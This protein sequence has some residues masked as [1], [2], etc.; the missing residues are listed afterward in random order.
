MVPLGLTSACRG[1]SEDVAAEMEDFLHHTKSVVTKGLERHLYLQEEVLVVRDTL[2]I[3]ED[4]GFCRFI[5]GAGPGF[6]SLIIGGGS[7]I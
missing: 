4:P 1:F 5:K 3:G 2:I 6:Q 7:S